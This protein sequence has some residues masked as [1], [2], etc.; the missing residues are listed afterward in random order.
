MNI[1]TAMNI[2]AYYHHYKDKAMHHV[3]GRRHGKETEQL[4]LSGTFVFGSSY[5]VKHR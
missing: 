3:S 2:C 1:P 5:V 4:G